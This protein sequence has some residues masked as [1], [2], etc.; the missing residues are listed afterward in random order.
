MKV[1]ATV[2]NVSGVVYAGAGIDT[3]SVIIELSEPLPP[4]LK[5]YLEIVKWDIEHDRPIYDYLSFS[6]LDESQATK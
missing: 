6:L 5:Q 4:L 1:I 3:K 2:T